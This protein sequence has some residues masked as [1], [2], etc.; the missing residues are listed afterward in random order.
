MQSLKTL[1]VEFTPAIKGFPHPI[2]N[3]TSGFALHE[4]SR[5][6]LDRSLSEHSV[7]IPKAITAYRIDL[8]IRLSGSH[9]NGGN[10]DQRIYEAYT[11]ADDYYPSPQL[12]VPDNAIPNLDRYIEYVGKIPK[13]D[14]QSIILSTSNGDWNG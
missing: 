10:C 14:A 6:E 1:A 12:S 7:A 11:R 3:E 9:S 5:Q 4:Y 8:S 13:P 2:F